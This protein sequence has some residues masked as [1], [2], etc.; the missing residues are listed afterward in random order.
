MEPQHR[1]R[2][3]GGSFGK[4]RLIIAAVMVLISLVGYYGARSYNPVTDEVQHVSI[5]PEQEVA[6]GLQAAPSMAQQHGGLHPDQQAQQRVDRICHELVEKTGAKETDYQFDCHVLADESTVNAF[7]L[8]GGQVF[9][10]A[11]LMAK[12]QNEGQLAGVLSHEIGHVVARH[13]AEHIAKQ[14]L[15]QGLTGAAVIASYDPDNPA[16]RRNAGVALVIGQLVNMRFGRQDELESDRLGVRF[17]SEAGYDPREMIGVM[18]ILA[19]SGGG[20]RQPE[21][22]S[23]HP[24]PKNRV[25]NIEAAIRE[26]SSWEAQAR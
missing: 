19:E 5:T 9:I 14:K 24:N 21:F 1:R 8:P 23:T 6:L 15:T 3:R 2:P 12:L 17:L 13:G 11:G 4:G 10:T 7:A 20:S 22:F 18:K 16:S 25:A 26:T